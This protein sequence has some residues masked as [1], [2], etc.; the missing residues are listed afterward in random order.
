VTRRTV[1]LSIILILLLLQI[2]VSFTAPYWA[3]YLRAPLPA[4]AEE[5]GALPQPT[6]TPEATA[7]GEVERTINVRLYFEAPDSRGLVG[8]VRAIPYSNDLGQQ[9]RSVVEELA[10]GSQS[11]WVAPLPPEARVLDVFVLDG[12]AYVDLSK[13]AFDKS[14]GGSDAEL[15]SVFAIVNSIAVNFP[16]IVRVCLLVDGRPAAT[17]AGHIDLSRPLAANMAYLAPEPTPTPVVAASPSAESTPTPPTTPTPP[18]PVAHPT[19]P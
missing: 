19:A 10:R 4:P 9:L 2:G 3:R 12:I 1:T 11:G 13:E 15:L 14:G 16:A 7:P 17:L 5:E 8:E 18:A 6:R